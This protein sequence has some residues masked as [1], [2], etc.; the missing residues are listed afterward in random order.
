MRREEALLKKQYDIAQK[1]TK[2]ALENEKF[3]MKMKKVGL[4]TNAKK[5]LK[6]F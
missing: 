5:D 1:E 6:L 4:W 3:T 2:K